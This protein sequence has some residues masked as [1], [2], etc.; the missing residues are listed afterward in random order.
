M[1][2]EGSLRRGPY[3]EPERPHVRDLPPLPE[4]W[5]WATVDQ[6]T[7]GGRKCAYGV[8]VP[9]PDVRDGVPLV[10]VGDVA[11]GRVRTSELKRISRKIADKFSKTY[12]EGG[13]V[14]ISLVGTIGRTAIVPESLK[15]A[16]VARAIGVIPITHLM[17]ARWVDVWLRSPVQRATMVGKAHEVARKTLNLEDVRSAL[18][19]LPP[20]SEQQRIVK[21]LEDLESVADAVTADIDG[22]HQR[23]ARLRQSVL[24]W[25]FAGKLVDQ[26]PTDEPA[27]VLLER[28]RKEREEAAAAAAGS[29]RARPRRPRTRR[30][31]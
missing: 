13:E 22:A 26:D 7:S 18:V 28:I 30:A 25:A 17:P 29:R 11:D 6:L 24:R 23:C 9:G 5:C 20:A 12:L 31:P 27:A 8:L 14:L 10:R 16:N 2:W 21:Q 15:G 4:G 1:R 3:A 19:A